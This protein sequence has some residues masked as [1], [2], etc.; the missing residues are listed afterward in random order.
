MGIFLTIIITSLTTLIITIISGTVIEYLKKIKP[1]LIVG[2]T[3]AVPINIEGKMIGANVVKIKNVSSKTIKDISVKIKASSGQIRDGGIKCTEALDYKI[4]CIDNLMIVT[5]PFLKL[6]DQVSITTITES[7]GHIAKKPDLNV[8]SPDVFKMISEEKTMYSKSYKDLLFPAV[9][10]IITPVLAFIIFSKANSSYIRDQSNDLTVAAS[11]A[12]LPILVERYA[13][14]N[15][16]NYYPS[17]AL[18]YSLAKAS[19]N[20]EDINK[21][22][23]FLEKLLELTDGAIMRK[24]SRCAVHYYLGKI[25]LLLE[26]NNQARKELNKAKEYCE[27]EYGKLS[28]LDNLT[29]LNNHSARK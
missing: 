28:Q 3:E 8:R 13:F 20:P 26:N 25:Y 16:V 4:E 14:N 10:A 11:V 22:R 21:Y 27:K 12:E 6:N 18:A 24:E 9:V 19:N 29:I 7:K 15:K 1:K 5:F 23:I 17:G 2:I